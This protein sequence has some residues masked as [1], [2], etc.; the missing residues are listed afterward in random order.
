FREAS[1]PVG[2][3]GAFVL[4][5]LTSAHVDFIRRLLL[6]PARKLDAVRT[7]A[8]ATFVELGVSRPHGRSGVLLYISLFERRV[9]VVPDLGIDARALGPEWKTAVAAVEQSLLPAPDLD[10]FL[11]AMRALGPILGRGLPRAADD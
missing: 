8:R 3:V 6:F 2:L 9:E 5:A 1:F 10:R 11:S 7:A 4:G